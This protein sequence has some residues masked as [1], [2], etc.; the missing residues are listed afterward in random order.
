VLGRLDPAELSA[1]GFTCLKSFLPDERVVPAPLMPDGGPDS[2]TAP[3]P[4]AA[5]QADPVRRAAR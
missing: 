4:R 1:P 5:A 3:G 2:R